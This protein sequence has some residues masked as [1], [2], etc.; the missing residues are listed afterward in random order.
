MI[1]E[2]T[3]LI[4]CLIGLTR[5]DPTFP[6]DLREDGLQ[7]CVDLIEPHFRN[8]DG[9]EINGDVL[10]NSRRINH[11]IIFECKG[12]KDANGEHL[13]DQIRK[14]KKL[15]KENVLPN[16]STSESNKFDFDVSFVFSEK[17]ETP[18]PDYP[19]IGK[20]FPV[21]IKKDF[22]I[23]KSSDYGG[24]K[25]N[26]LNI[27]FSRGISIPAETPTK[28]YPFGCNDP[29]ISIAPFILQSIVHL[30][31]KKREGFTEEDILKKSH[32][33]WNNFDESHKAE[34]KKKLNSIMK[35][36]N[37]NK[38]NDH[39][40]KTKDKYK[41]NSKTYQSLNETCEKIKQELQKD[42][43]QKEISEWK[44]N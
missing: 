7:Y 27:L 11:G 16:V 25:R 15:Q 20:S 3:I 22:S 41:I 10:L 44:G 38:I 12:G 13:N 8:S 35:S 2:H 28:Y 43:E 29:L 37:F 5:K 1:T 34:M 21:L 26:E 9:E 39:I 14:Y 42:K 19:T 17:P 4:N 31:I 33:L 30:A 6:S 23:S 40:I 36:K 24:F 18:L 32:P